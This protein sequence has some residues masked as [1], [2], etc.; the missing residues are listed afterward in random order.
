MSVQSLK[1]NNQVRANFLNAIKNKKI[2]IILL[3]VNVFGLPYAILQLG[4]FSEGSIF[5]LCISAFALVVNVIMGMVIP[6]LQ[7][8]YCYDRTKVDMAYS[9]PLTRRQ[10]FLSDFFSGLSMYVGAYLIQILLTYLSTTITIAI[11]NPT[12]SLNYYFYRLHQMSNLELYQMVSK[13]LLIILLM[14]IMLYVVTTFVLSCTGAIFEAVSAIIYTNILLASTIYVIY[15]LCANQLFGMDFSN[16]LAQLLYHTSPL[17][18]FFYLFLDGVTRANI[19]GWAIG[20]VIMIGIYF[21]LT[22]FIMTRRKAE[23]VGKPFVV[24]SFYHIILVSIMLHIGLLACYTGNSLVT[25]IL[26]TLIFYL[27]VETI[28]NRGFKKF[29]KSLARYGIIIACTLAVILT[30]NKTACFG[31]AYQVADVSD[32]DQIAL[33]YS[34]L[35]ANQYFRNIKITSKDSIATLLEVQQD[36]IDEYKARKGQET[37]GIF[38]WRVGNVSYHNSYVSSGLQ[39]KVE[40]KENYF[41]YYNISYQNMLRLVDVELSDEYVDARIESYLDDAG[42][43]SVA[44]I[45]GFKE[46]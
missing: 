26:M 39:I 22:Y 40:G 9:L 46:I 28:T 14:Q 4:V 41:R 43:L 15:T 10:K 42:F 37:S 3:L 35:F 25:F 18:G 2:W 29:G 11:G 21:L 1:T 16:V 8:D 30:I 12:N 27:V 6:F 45:F 44:D 13:I 32:V 33:S 38:D 36:V 20:Y 17:G 34:G 31:I 23:S 7:F 19:S 24:R 5:S